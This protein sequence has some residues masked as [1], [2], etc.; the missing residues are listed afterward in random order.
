MVASCY[1][2][3]GAYPAALKLYE[4][5]HKSHPN[6]IE[7]VRY[8]ITICKEMKQKY[9]HYAAHLRKL[10]RLQEAQNGQGGRP[11]GT[12]SAIDDSPHDDGGRMGFGGSRGHF[13]EDDPPPAPAD[14]P[15]PPM[16][17]WYS[18]VQSRSFRMHLP[19]VTKPK[20]SFPK[21]LPCYFPILSH[22]MS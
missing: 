3:M 10:E 2:R 14:P 16:A 19:A 6:D 7:C 18:L 20:D 5:I 17:A 22:K 11:M 21:I 15:R 8:L 4:D 9:D 12:V 1:R 13:D